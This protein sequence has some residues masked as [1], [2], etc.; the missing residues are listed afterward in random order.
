LSVYFFLIKNEV[1]FWGNTL[2]IFSCPAMGEPH[3]FQD[4]WWILPPCH[5]H[6]GDCPYCSL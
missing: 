4:K 2:P 6:K 3:Q 1:P 5:T